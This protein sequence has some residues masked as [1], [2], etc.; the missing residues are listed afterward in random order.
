MC[1]NAFLQELSTCG[2]FKDLPPPCSSVGGGITVKLFNELHIHCLR[3]SI[4]PPCLYYIQPVLGVTNKGCTQAECLYSSQTECSFGG[5]IST[6][7]RRYWSHLVPP[8]SHLLTQH[9]SL[10]L[11]YPFIGPV[12]ELTPMNNRCHPLRL[13]DSCSPC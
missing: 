9:Y 7:L 13:N 3:C 6:S 1:E 12:H 2:D 5:T 8:S 11:F 10:L 4:T